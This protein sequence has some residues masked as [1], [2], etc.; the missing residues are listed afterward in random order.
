MN[1]RHLVRAA[2]SGVGLLPSGGLAPPF[3]LAQTVRTGSPEYIGAM[4]VMW[5]SVRSARQ[6][7]SRLLSEPNREDEEWRID[8]LAPFAVVVAVRD[9]TRTIV[10]PPKY[11]SAHARWLAALDT[12]VTAGTYLR[13]GILTDNEDTIQLARRSLTRA[14]DLLIQVEVLLPRRVLRPA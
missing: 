12:L 13:A 4:T 7:I 3:A 6:D 11:V 5:R 9:T 1:R 8:V 2:A 14:E 10:P